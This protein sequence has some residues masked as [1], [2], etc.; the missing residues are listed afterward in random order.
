[1]IT[2]QVRGRWKS[3]PQRKADLVPGEYARAGSGTR[4]VNKRFSA[5]EAP[6]DCVECRHFF[7][8]LERELS[9]RSRTISTQ[10]HRIRIT[11]DAIGAEDLGTP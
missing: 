5:P 1:L 4:H 11:R 2:N 10:V 9:V 6:R 8:V 3:K 7:A